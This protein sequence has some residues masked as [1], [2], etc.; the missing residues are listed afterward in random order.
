MNLYK[1]LKL[2]FF[3]RFMVKWRTPLSL[4]QAKDWHSVS[5]LSKSRASIKG[6]FARSTFGHEKATI[7]LGHPMGKEAKGYFI[8]NG[9]TDILRADGFNVLIFDI[10]GFG[11]SSMGN[12][13]YFEDILAIGREAAKLTPDLSIGYHGISL[14]GQW[15]TIAFTDINHNYNFAIIESAATTLEEFWIKFPVAYRMLSILNF[16]LPKYRRK[17]RMIDRIKEVQH[18]KSLLLIYSESDEWVPVDM[19]RRFLNNSPVK[20][21][22]WT[23]KN[24]GHASMMKSGHKEIYTRKIL[25]YFNESL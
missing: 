3:S 24:A 21:E 7:V 11:E 2:P 18:L 4:E 12:F 25:E 17:I 19:G 10:N 8:K 14:G 15:A 1:L 6:L 13:S 5:V 22:L 23:V 9:Y 16:I 20:T